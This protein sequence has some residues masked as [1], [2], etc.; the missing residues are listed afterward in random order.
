MIFYS[1]GN[2]EATVSKT[3]NAAKDAFPTVDSASKDIGD[4]SVFF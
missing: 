1:F 2:T 3:R 4:A